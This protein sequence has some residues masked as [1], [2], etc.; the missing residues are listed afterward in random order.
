MLERIRRTS[1]GTYRMRLNGEE[2]EA[3]RVIP[4]RLRE[5]LA[6][7]A[8]AGDPAFQRLFPPAFLDDDEATKEFDDLTRTGLLEERL[9]AIDEMERSL[10]STT[11]SEDELLAWMGAMNDYRLV[12]GVRLNI[13]EDFDVSTY[14]DHGQREELM[15]YRFLSSMQEQMVRALSGPSNA[16]LAWELVRYRKEN[17]DL[18]LGPLGEQPGGQPGDPAGEDDA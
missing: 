5:L 11:L 12:L 17:P 2:R 7:D 1:K 6:E 13:S 8:D 16:K 3:L 14:T 15:L 9:A 4:Q 10:W 18:D